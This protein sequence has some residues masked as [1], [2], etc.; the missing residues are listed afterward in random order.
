MFEKSKSAITFKEFQDKMNTANDFD[1]DW[2]H[3]CYLDP[4]NNSTA[5]TNA[6][7]IILFKDTLDNPKRE[8]KKLFQKEQEENLEEDLK[9]LKQESE[10][11]KEIEKIIKEI[12]IDIEDENLEETPDEDDNK[13]NKPYLKDNIKV[14]IIKNIFKC[15]EVVFITSI[16]GYFIFN[17]L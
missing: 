10:D 6:N 14:T 4:S 17:I 11:S 3:F 2:G 8:F 1:N 12:F 9:Q 7:T 5:T 16:M 13:K 15:F